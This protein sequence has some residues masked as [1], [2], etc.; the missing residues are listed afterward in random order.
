MIAG[1][2][3]DLRLAARVLGRNPGFTAAAVFVL[4]L[5]LGANTAIFNLFHA[6]LIRPLPG[7]VQPGRLVL[8]G[9]TPGGQGFDTIS[10]PDYLDY[11]ERNQVFEGVA[12][13]REHVLGLNATGE[14]ARVSGAVVS[15]NYFTVL[16]VTPSL[17]RAFRAE[18][19]DLHGGG[20]VA[21][22]S[23]NLWRRLYGSSPAVLG[24]AI[25]VNGRSLTVIGVTPPGFSGTDVR[26]PSIDI[27]IPIGSPVPV[28]RESA[29][30]AVR[31]SS[32]LSAIGRLRPGVELDQAQANL[33]AIARWIAQEHPSA[34]RD[35]GISVVPYH[36]LGGGDARRDTG[37]MLAVVLL[38]TVLVL[39]IAC[40]NVAGLLLARASTRGREVAIRQ[41]MGASRASLVRQFLAEGIFLSLVSCGASLAACVWTAGLLPRFFPAVEGV[42]PALDLHPGL[43]TVAYSIGMALVASVVFSLAPALGSARLDVSSVLKSGEISAVLRSSRFRDALVVAQVALSVALL[44][45]AGLLVRTLHSMRSIDPLMKT[46]TVLLAS[47]DPGLDG[48]DQTSAQRFQ[49]RLLERASMLPGVEAASVAL[50]APFT[51]SGIFMSLVGGVVGEAKGLASGYNL[52]GPDYL[53]TAGIEIARGRDFGVQD[54]A[55]SPRVVIVNQT[56][57]RRLWPGQDPLGKVVRLDGQ[58]DGW[59]VVGV[60]RD[61]RYSSAFETA[62]PFHYLPLFQYSSRLFSHRAPDLTL[63]LRIGAG[64]ADVVGPLRRLVRELDPNLPL[65]NI[66]T[67]RAQ[68][69]NLFWPWRMAATLVGIFSLMAAAMATVGLYAVIAC[70]VSRRR[71]EIGMRMALGAAPREIL[72]STV[73][74]GMRLAAGGLVAGILLAVAG[75]RV[76]GG[77]LYGVKPADP[78]T[79]VSVAVL[80]LG[81]TLIASYVPA[82]RAARVD[83]TRVLRY[84]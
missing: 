12:A 36:G 67:V 24:T 4:A 60:A 46:D 65:Y 70:R 22:I 33:G 9:R 83:P 45:A 68:F 26:K 30:S 10:Y 42:P 43:S 81:T 16:G 51:N 20:A 35:E 41:A 38:T 61:S 53:R 73:L 25:A 76:L 7:I 63:H 21:L 78:V 47:L 84:E 54:H 2:L 39:L 58:A 1:F 5:G 14:T 59:A 44:A 57:A 27:W 11:R 49:S 3:K 82:R 52:V 79:Y 62:R 32:C 48:Y 66:R 71:F 69:D 40:A 72:K 75:T 64:S 28:R 77:F 34:Y 15:A 80:L 19:E 17:G 55:S 37:R 74:D 56:L 29:V 6:V 8:I 31:E 18:E 50:L 23:H 13:Y